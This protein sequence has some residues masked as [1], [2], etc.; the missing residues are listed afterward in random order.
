LIQGFKGMHRIAT[1]RPISQ[2]G[3]ILIELLVA[4][5]ISSI[6][7]I[8]LVQIVQASRS[9]FR[10]QENQAEVQENGRYALTTLAKIIQ[11][12]AFSPQPWNDSFEPQGI[13][14]ETQDRVTSRSD[15]LAVRSWSNTNCFDNRNPIV[16]EFGEAAF[17]IRESRFDLNDRRDL[18]HTCRYGPTEADL[19]TQVNREGFVRNVE[20]FQVLYA[21]DS[22]ADG[23]VDQW[24]KGGDWSNEQLIIGVRVGLLLN[25]SDSVV[26]RT[27]QTFSILDLTYKTPAD[28]KLR[29]Q[30]AFTTAIK[31]RG[32]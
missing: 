26:E 17:Y 9:S 23:H 31:S 27:S 20:S 2:S 25:S 11:Q 12:T 16:D 19:V 4:V 14:P 10:L 21:Q 6:L 18:T 24:V 29:L 3:L 8:G 5:L 32:G 7:I 13:T 22:N 15:R 30:L 28:G 1:S